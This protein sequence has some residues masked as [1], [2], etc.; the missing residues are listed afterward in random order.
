MAVLIAMYGHLAEFRASYNFRD[1][2]LDY[3][4]KAGPTVFQEGGHD[5]ETH[6]FY[7]ILPTCTQCVQL[8]TQV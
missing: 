1:G 6:Q 4:H 7:F 8:I 2:V 3:T 5:R